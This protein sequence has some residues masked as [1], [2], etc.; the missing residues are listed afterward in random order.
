[1]SRLLQVEIFVFNFQNLTIANTRQT[2]KRL[3]IIFKNEKNHNQLD[4]FL[5]ASMIKEFTRIIRVE[6]TIIMNI[7]RE[8]HAISARRCPSVVYF[9]IRIQCSKDL[10]TVLRPI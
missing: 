4:A 5:I 3:L 7:N 8:R 10:H 9:N 1:M 6:I 2:R